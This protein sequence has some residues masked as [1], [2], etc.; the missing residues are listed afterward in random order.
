[1]SEKVRKRL[2][3][4]LKKLNKSI[5]IQHMDVEISKEIYSAYV[6]LHI[7]RISKSMASIFI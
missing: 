2:K 4:V 6:K 3:D 7:K 5:S 1:M